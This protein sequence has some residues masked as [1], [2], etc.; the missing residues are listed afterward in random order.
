MMLTD[1]AESANSTLIL[2]F[3]LRRVKQL[4]YT[5]RHMMGIFNCKRCKRAL[6]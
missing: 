1:F 2:G 5:Y 6:E 3:Q 4:F